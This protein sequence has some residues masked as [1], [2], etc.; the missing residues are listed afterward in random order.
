MGRSLMRAAGMVALLALIGGLWFVRGSA[1]ADQYASKPINIL[2]AFSAGGVVDISAGA[3]TKA[4]TE[5]APFVKEG[6][7]RAMAEPE[8]LDTLAK[9]EHEPTYR[10]PEE[11]KKFLKQAWV[12]YGEMIREIKLPGEQEQKK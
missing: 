9:I 3:L 5:W 7:L 4:G 11:T 8:F 10:G 1:A 6:R 12:R 2:V